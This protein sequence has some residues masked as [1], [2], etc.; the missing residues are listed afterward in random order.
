MKKL[1][2]SSREY[3]TVTGVQVGKVLSFDVSTL[4]PRPPPLGPLFIGP[5]GGKRRNAR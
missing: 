5:R 3:R 4:H 1:C 2:M